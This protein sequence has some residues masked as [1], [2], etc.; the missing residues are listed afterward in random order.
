MSNF[1]NP[2]AAALK[3][4]QKLW[5]AVTGVIFKPVDSCVRA[6]FTDVGMFAFAAGFRDEALG[7]GLDKR[8]EIKSHTPSPE[9]HRVNM[10]FHDAGEPVSVFMQDGK[11]VAPSLGESAEDH[12]EFCE[13]ALKVLAKTAF[14]AQE[15]KAA[16]DATNKFYCYPAKP[17]KINDK[18]VVEVT[19]LNANQIY[20]E[21]PELLYLH[22]LCRHLQETQGSSWRVPPESTGEDLNDP[23]IS[24]S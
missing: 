12:V 1:D 7:Q 16:V 2:Y 14:S 21:F 17:I 20:D 4:E 15:S 10:I 13:R 18:T 22:N 9:S 11:L 5:K 6:V 23:D 24:G 19:G 8:L 3:A